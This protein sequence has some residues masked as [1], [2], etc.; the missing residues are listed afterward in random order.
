MINK[1]KL[2]GRNEPCLCGSGVKF[3]KCCENIGPE[4]YHRIWIRGEVD[5]WLEYIKIDTD[6]KPGQFIINYMVELGMEAEAIKLGYI[7]PKIKF[8]NSHSHPAALG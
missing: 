6:A 4:G 3:K 5:R 8:N 7:K 1:N 2:P